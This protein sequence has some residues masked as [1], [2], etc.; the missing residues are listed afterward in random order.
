MSGGMQSAEP[1]SEVEGLIARAL[2]LL[3]IHHPGRDA[4]IG[5]LEEALKTLEIQPGG[6]PPEMLSSANDG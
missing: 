2:D 4:A 6:I 3:R 1:L 5:H